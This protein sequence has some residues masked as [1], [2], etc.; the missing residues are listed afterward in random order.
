[1]QHVHSMT[2][3]FLAIASCNFNSTIISQH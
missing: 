2:K 3:T 1:M